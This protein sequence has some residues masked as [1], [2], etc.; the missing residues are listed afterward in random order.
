[1]K[2]LRTYLTIFPHIGRPHDGWSTGVLPRGRSLFY[3][4]RPRVQ[5]YIRSKPQEIMTGWLYGSKLFQVRE[6]G[7]MALCL[8]FLRAGRLN[9]RPQLPTR[10]S[11]LSSAI[12]SV[13]I[14][15]LFPPF[16]APHESSRWHRASHAEW[17]RTPFVVRLRVPLFFRIIYLPFFLWDYERGEWPLL[18]SP[19][20]LLFYYF[21][22][23]V[24][25]LF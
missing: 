3:D 13:S 20:I 7:F 24:L 8:P 11:S 2:L 5:Y 19:R 23:R 16:T 4:P 18:R 15:F 9:K 21:I 1:M 14:F 25:M 22:L 6:G 17:I 10:L 12:Y